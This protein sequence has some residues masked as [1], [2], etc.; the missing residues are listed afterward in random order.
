MLGRANGVPLGNGLG[1]RGAIFWTEHGCLHHCTARSGTLIVDGLSILARPYRAFF[2]VKNGSAADGPLA[3][4]FQA[5]LSSISM[6]DTSNGKVLSSV[7][8]G[9][10]A[11]AVAVDPALGRVYVANSGNG[12]VSVFAE[13]TA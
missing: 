2:V 13:S 3:A 11:A 6:I 10:G 9:K 4:P 5:G 1:G 12:T 8:L 7:G